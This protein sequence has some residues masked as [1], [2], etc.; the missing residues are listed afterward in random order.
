MSGRL[1]KAVLSVPVLEKKSSPTHFPTTGF[2]LYPV[3]EKKLS[4]TRFP[5]TGFHLYPVLPT[6]F[7]LRLLLKPTMRNDVSTSVS[8]V[9][10]ENKAPLN[11]TP[12]YLSRPQPAAQRALE[13]ALAI[14]TNILGTANKHFKT[15]TAHQQLPLSP[16]SWAAHTL[17]LNA[18]TA[19]A[20]HI[21]RAISITTHSNHTSTQHT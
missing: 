6:R 1:P 13:L 14:L 21:S 15:L 20:R 5:T 8:I 9:A 16:T 3:L 7:Q 19:L 18:S 2:H 17:A 4:P 10:T 11:P 12:T